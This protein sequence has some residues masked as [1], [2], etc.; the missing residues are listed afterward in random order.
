MLKA[1][2]DV[3][4]WPQR[5]L[6]DIN[7]TTVIYC[8]SVEQPKWIFNNKELH[9]QSNTLLIHPT[10]YEDQGTYKR[11]GRT[12]TGRFFAAKSVISIEVPIAHC[13]LF[14]LFVHST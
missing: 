10:S 12:N 5:Q 14:C 4:I 2:V 7:S 13:Y 3:N 8:N 9:V 1:S 6:V 11:Y